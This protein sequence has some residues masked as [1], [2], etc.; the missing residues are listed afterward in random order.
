MR[1]MR[2]DE[3]LKTINLFEGDSES[4]GIS[5]RALKNWVVNISV[6]M[7]YENKNVFVLTLLLCYMALCISNIC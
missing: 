2:D 6:H 5:R 7:C 3:A 4:K 1:F